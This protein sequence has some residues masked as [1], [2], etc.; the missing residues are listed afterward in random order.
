MIKKRKKERK[1]RAKLKKMEFS[2]YMVQKVG[3]IKKIFI[4]LNLYFNTYVIEVS[5]KNL[6]D[7]LNFRLVGYFFYFDKI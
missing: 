3:K 4:N 7:N 2:I 6:L 5:Y 1:E